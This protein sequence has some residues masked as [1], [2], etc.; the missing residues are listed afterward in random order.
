MDENSALE[1]ER[2]EIEKLKPDYNQMMSP[3]Q[4]A[5]E[6]VKFKA[7]VE[8]LRD[9]KFM[10]SVQDEIKG[11][12]L[13]STKAERKIEQIDK[14]AQVLTKESEKN[15]GYYLKHKPVL[16]FGGIDDPCDMALMKLSFSL[17]VLP[18][19]ISALFIKT[20][21]RILSVVFEE[22][23]KLLVSITKFTLPAKLLF[24]SVIWA[25]IAGGLVITIIKIIEVLFGI[26]LWR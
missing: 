22:F 26:A 21:L 16:N 5:R 17:M 23:N 18:Y 10:E 4:N 19:F 14:S 6:A 11:G 12:I 7:A 1:N 8:T 25:G 2:P 15:A 9:E 13:E 24:Q 3:S 20:P